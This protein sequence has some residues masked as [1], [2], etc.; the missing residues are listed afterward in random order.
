MDDKKPDQTKPEDRAG[1]VP[2]NALVMHWYCFSYHGKTLDGGL[3][4]E[5]STYTGYP[6]KKV[7]M[8][9]IN[10][11]KENAGVTLLAVLTG[12]SY[13]GHMTREEFTSEA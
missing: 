10:E 9:M 5:S 8:K 12:C 7:T 6:L 13:L 3:D 1:K 4:C 2:V 11:N